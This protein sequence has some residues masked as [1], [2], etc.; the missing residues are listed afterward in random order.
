MP[1]SRAEQVVGDRA[2]R[3]GDVFG[4]ARRAGRVDDV[5][6]VGR[7]QRGTALRVGEVLSRP[8]YRG[9]DRCGDPV[10]VEDQP[11]CRVLEQELG[12]GVGVVGVDRQVGGT[13]P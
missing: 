1:S 9:C 11:R 3:H 13:G 2:V 5:G 10:G 8:V 4:H 7:A 6:Q 12:A